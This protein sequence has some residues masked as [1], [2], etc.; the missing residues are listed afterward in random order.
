MIKFFDK[1]ADAKT[2]A[3]GSALYIIDGPEDNY[4]VVDHETAC[5]IQDTDTPCTDYEAN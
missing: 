5:D 1:L 2:Y 4:A 3:K